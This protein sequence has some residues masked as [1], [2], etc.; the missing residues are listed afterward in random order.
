MPN[1]KCQECSSTLRVSLAAQGTTIKCPRC[2][3][4]I[5]VPQMRLA[6]RGGRPREARPA[7][8]D[9][10]AAAH[11]ITFECSSCQ[12]S[13]EASDDL[14]GE[15][16]P[17]P[18]C[19]TPVT[20]PQGQIESD[21]S[22]AT[23]SQSRK[24]RRLVTTLVIV[25][26]T[27]LVVLSLTMVVTHFRGDDAAKGSER[28]LR[29]NARREASRG[30]TVSSTSYPPVATFSPGR[31]ETPE[32][33][34]RVGMW[35]FIAPSDGLVLNESIA[36]AGGT[37]AFYGD[38]VNGSRVGVGFTSVYRQGK[39]IGYLFQ[40]YDSDGE[41]PWMTNGS[42]IVFPMRGP[43]GSSDFD[44]TSLGRQ[45]RLSVALGAFRV[46]GGDFAFQRFLTPAV[47]CLSAAPPGP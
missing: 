35:L 15:V 47:T 39:F 11:D 2:S 31:L 26:G 7:A 16:V 13:L 30:L 17:C 36:G 37:G 27:L 4:E 29:S 25:G 6:G 12:Q 46:Q 24:R 43:Y 10:V 33:G 21:H 3:A 20:V 40:V 38:E 19:N 41:Y 23:I 45:A 32:P 34:E 42:P 28:A 14:A 8:A 1:V 5:R 18:A 22:V 9:N 44:W